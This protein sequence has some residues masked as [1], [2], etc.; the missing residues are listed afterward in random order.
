[1][2]VIRRVDARSP[3]RPPLAL[4]ASAHPELVEGPTRSDDRRSDCP[5][6]GASRTAPYS[7]SMPSELSA[8]SDQLADA[9]Q[10]A[11]AWTVRVHARR[12]YP[13]SGIA[14]A[15]DL[16]LTADHVVDPAREDAIRLGLPRRLRSKRHARRSRRRHRPRHPARKRRFAH[17]RHR[18]RRR[19]THRCP[20]ARR[21]PT[22]RRRERQSRP[23]HGPGRTRPHPPR[24]HARTLHPGRR[25]PVS[26]L[27]GRTAGRC[28][29]APCWA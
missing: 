27:L 29:A 8:F 14:L 11:A 15:A 1:M 16:V 4:A 17:A 7:T 23:G 20:G 28:L 10:T 19:A 13:A 25:R 24:R 9:V 12:G 26:G 2:P 5:E 22:R 6:D 3:A 21:R 18:G